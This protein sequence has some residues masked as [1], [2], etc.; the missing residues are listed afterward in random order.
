MREFSTVRVDPGA[1]ERPEPVFGPTIGE[2]LD[3]AAA[4]VA[5][6][7][8]QARVENW[9]EEQYHA[10]R[11]HL[12]R[13]KLWTFKESRRRFEG[14]CVTFTAPPAKPKDHFDIGSLVHAACLE[15]HRLDDKFIAWPEGM[16]SDGD[17][18]RTNAA[19]AWRDQQR[20][21]GRIPMKAR[22]MAVV[23]SCAESVSA[24]CGQW[25][26]M[27]TAIEQTILWREPESEILCRCR[28]D[29]QL[30]TDDAIFAFD[31]KTAETVD[32]H[33]FRANCEAH[34][35]WLQASHYSAGITA[36][37]GKP[38]IFHFVAVEKSWPFRTRI[39]RLDDKSLADANSRRHELLS[40]LADCLDTK[41]FA[42][43]WERDITEIAIRPHSFL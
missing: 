11:K 30:P 24:A 2:R 37:T 42:E 32:A 14:E 17:A 8:N 16:L 34:G 20:A 12:S 36:L 27:A 35:L 23:M 43:P 13:G 25:I 29:F 31:L 10:D 19:K 5:P 6:A 9:T 18:C 33:A 21:A 22:D 1:C 3:G 40:E 7:A 15:P 4:M 41:D 28:P 39:F 26:G 38:C